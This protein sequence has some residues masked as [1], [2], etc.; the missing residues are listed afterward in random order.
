MP[1]I[2]R[3]LG[4]VIAMYYTDHEP[5]H[6][7]ARYGQFQATIGI[8]DGRLLAGELPPRV[9][10]LIEEWRAI[11]RQE[12]FDDWDRARQRLPLARVAPLA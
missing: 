12:L 8:A 2:C 10:G 11:H 4:I 6:F 9:Q 1:E 7:H 5:P 3:F